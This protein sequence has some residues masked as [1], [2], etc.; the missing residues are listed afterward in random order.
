MSTKS[1]ILQLLQRE[2][3]TVVQLCEHLAVTRNAVIVQLKQLE[4]EGLVR[5]SKIRPPNTVGKPPVVFEAAPGSEDVTSTAYQVL[6]TQLLA[7]LKDRYNA[8]ELGEVL[9]Q[10]G[11]Q[12]A[13]RAG[14]ANPATFDSGLCSAMAAADAL[15]ASTEA[16]AQE[17]GVMVRNFTCPVG[18]VVREEQCVCRAMAA[19]FSEATGM[20]ASE[21]CLREDRLICQYFIEKSETPKG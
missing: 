19:F 1:D 8:D 3:L 12:L 17:G 9:E 18:S 21:Q 14:L 16:V 5:R 4:S 15:G 20:P 2:P 13:Q 11:R 7:T 10:T 6:L